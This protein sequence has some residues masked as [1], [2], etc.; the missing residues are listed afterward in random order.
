M[1]EP[2][3]YGVRNGLAPILLTHSDTQGDI[4][5]AENIPLLGSSVNK[6]KEKGRGCYAP[7]LIRYL[8]LPFR[9]DMTVS[10]D[11]GWLLRPFVVTLDV[12]PFDR[13]PEEKWKFPNER[14]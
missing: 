7:A 5:A 8:A 12:Y 1:K 11:V 14:T 6:G 3:R 10:R 4:C 2:K 9:S 13:K